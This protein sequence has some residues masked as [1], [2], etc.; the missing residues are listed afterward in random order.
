MHYHVACLTIA[1]LVQ[2]SDHR[3]ALYEVVFWWLPVAS[4]LAMANRRAA[5]ESF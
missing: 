2:R 1:K 5:I 4:L 3:K